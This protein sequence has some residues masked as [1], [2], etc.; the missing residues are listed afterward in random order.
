MVSASPTRSPDS[1]DNLNITTYIYMNKYIENVKVME[2]VK[3]ESDTTQ[4]LL[5]FN[6][7]YLISNAFR[8]ALREN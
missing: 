3:K 4:T 5:V 2:S 6:Y 1:G 8:Y 7:V